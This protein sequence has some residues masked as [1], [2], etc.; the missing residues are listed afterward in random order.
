MK[1]LL[2]KKNIQNNFQ[3]KIINEFVKKQENNE[4]FEDNEQDID[5]EEAEEVQSDKSDKND[6]SS[7]ESSVTTVEDEDGNETCD[8]E[9]ENSPV[10]KSNSNTKT[11]ETNGKE[12]L[13]ENETSEETLK[14]EKSAS[15]SIRDEPS[16]KDTA[17]KRSASL[18]DSTSCLNLS[19][20]KKQKLND[21]VEKSSSSVSL[22]TFLKAYKPE[23]R[24]SDLSNKIEVSKPRIVE[25]SSASQIADDCIIID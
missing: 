20:I 11:V 3:T 19:K 6:Q 25:C 18:Q 7:M 22:S 9:L 8:T 15:K 10:K 23:E 1:I 14:E 21:S 2:K 5:D 12:N 24:K 16:S 13:K 4:D 17:F